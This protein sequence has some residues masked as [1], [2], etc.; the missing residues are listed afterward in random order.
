MR[1][2]QF[3]L[4]P[5]SGNVPGVKEGGIRNAHFRLPIQPIRST[6][7]MNNYYTPLSFNAMLAVCVGLVRLPVSFSSFFIFCGE[8][9]IVNNFYLAVP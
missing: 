2:G 9:L 1:V 6:T 8:D 7:L 4:K 3:L 5:I